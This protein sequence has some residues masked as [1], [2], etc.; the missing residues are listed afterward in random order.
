M[1]DQDIYI[2]N[3]YDKLYEVIWKF[4]VFILINVNN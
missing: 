2:K 3:M 4:W 1:A